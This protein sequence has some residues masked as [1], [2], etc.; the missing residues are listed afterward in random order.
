MDVYKL[1]VK[2]DLLQENSA[3][4]DSAR[5]YISF[6]IVEPNAMILKNPQEWGCPGRS[7]QLDGTQTESRIENPDG[8]CQPLLSHFCLSLG[9]PSG[10]TQG[11]HTSD[12]LLLHCVEGPCSKRVKPS[13]LGCGLRQG[14]WWEL[15]SPAQQQKV[16]AGRWTMDL[17]KMVQPKERT[18]DLPTKDSVKDTSQTDSSCQMTTE[19][20]DRRYFQNSF[21]CMHSL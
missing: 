11:M 18:P 10:P 13:S 21:S 2:L 20:M 4:T 16:P 1:L 5:P 9:P 12:R 15:C 8:S 7:R 19:N 6:F 3:F 17:R 14:K